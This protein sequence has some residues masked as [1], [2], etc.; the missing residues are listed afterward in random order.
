M[1]YDGR[2]KVH[3]LPRSDFNKEIECFMGRLYCLYFL[4]L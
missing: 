4:Y 2:M 1:G 3:I